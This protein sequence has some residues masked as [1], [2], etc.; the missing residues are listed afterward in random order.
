[1]RPFA[2]KLPFIPVAINEPNCLINNYLITA[3]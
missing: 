3:E 1:L 2:S